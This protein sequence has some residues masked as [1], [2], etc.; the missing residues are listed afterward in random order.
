MPAATAAPVPDEDPPVK[1]SVFQG[2]RAGGQGKSKD[3]PPQANSWVASLP[4]I[5]APASRQRRTTAESIFGT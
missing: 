3:G 5:T 2:L 1:Y 4:S